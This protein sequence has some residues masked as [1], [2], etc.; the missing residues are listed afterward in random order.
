MTAKQ[1]MLKQK[2][3]RI[4]E[5]MTEPGV[6]IKDIIEELGFDSQGKLQPLLPKQTF[7]MYPQTN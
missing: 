5:K 1:W 7:R 3:Q 6:C 2:N 4:L